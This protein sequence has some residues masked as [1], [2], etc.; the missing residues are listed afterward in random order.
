[1]CQFKESDHDRMS[2]AF[3]EAIKRTKTHKEAHT[4]LTLMAHWMRN[5]EHE[6]DFLRY[7]QHWVNA[8]EDKTL[9]FD[10]VPIVELFG[11]TRELAHIKYH[12][13]DWHKDPVEFVITHQH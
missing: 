5:M 8:N 9:N 4:W 10:C 11:R 2:Y 6:V 1:M 12:G 3:R 13:T 7:A